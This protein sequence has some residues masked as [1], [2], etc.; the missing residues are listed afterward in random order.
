MTRARWL[1]VLALIVLFLA[2]AWYYVGSPLLRSFADRA[3]RA[4]SRPVIL[5][6]AAYPGANA[7]VVADT[8]AAPI[9]QQIN[10]VEDMLHMVSRSSNDGSYTL[11]VTFKPG[12]DMN[13]AQV[14]VQNRVALALPVLP[15]AVKQVGVTTRKKSA[16]MLMLVAVSSP[17]G[18]RDAVF[19]SHGAATDLKD[20][21]ARVSGVG[22]VNG[23]AVREA[24]VRVRIDLEKLA[25]Q[26]MTVA[27]VVK[28][29]ELLKI[30]LEPGQGREKVSEIRLLPKD[31]L[32]DR[33]E[34]ETII[35]RTTP[36][37]RVVYLKDVA[38][39]EIVANGPPVFA[40]L[41]GKP[42]AVLAL[43]PLPQ[44]DPR[45]V[46]K[47]VEDLLSRLRP[48]LR[49]GVAVDVAFDFAANLEAGDRAAPEYLLL[50]PA[51]PPDASPERRFRELGRYE[52]V[53]REVK[54][55]QDV[56]ALSDN[57]FDGVRDRPCV[58]VRLAPEG[59]E[60]PAREEIVKA[61]RTR[62]GEKGKPVRVRDLA[63]R[64]PGCGYPLDL[65][66]SG[67]EQDQ[68]GDWAEKVAGQ[69]GRND[70]LTDVWANPESRLQPQVYLDIDRTKAKEF[71]VSM[72]DV[73][74]TLQVYLEAFHVNDF[75]RFGRTW[76]VTIQAEPPGKLEDIKK[77][78]VRNGKGDMVPLGAFVAVREVKGP[79][80]LERLDGRPMVEITA[81]L[82][83]G[84]TLA[85][86]RTLCEGLAE[87]VR[88]ELKLPRE[89]RLT[90]LRE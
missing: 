52:E 20:E 60:R 2:A 19:L 14:L 7:A 37:R 84:L 39:V 83:P 41:N 35:L 49:K 24:G 4:R 64:F 53:L 85:E 76:Q 47:A 68:V 66:L 87:E 86:A 29:L 26:G 51:F 10:G 30:P 27:D 61:V 78:K 9:E 31:K 34:I 50:D 5:V 71:G 80:V 58:L 59:K 81:N 72:D 82:A 21:L 74:N 23:T 75:N 18:S 17:D 44:G 48:K 67:P 28:A 8:V 15:D 38:R 69:L 45:E 16:C 88:K 90:W 63:G 70:K 77:L 62:A 6:E 73:F 25:A 46:S 55:V 54:G 33:E 32:P 89:Y 42:V 79:V 1:V 43:S 56:L 11:T 36:E 57:P 65:A 40:R 3:A 12:T 13:I 22:D